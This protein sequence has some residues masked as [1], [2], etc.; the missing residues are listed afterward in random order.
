MQPP[1]LQGPYQLPAFEACS[2]HVSVTKGRQRCAPGHPDSSLRSLADVVHCTAGLD[3]HNHQME[4]QCLQI[5]FFRNFS[6]EESR[7]SHSRM[8]T[9]E[10][11]MYS[12]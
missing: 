2:A 6:L 9:S 7:L 12:A 1:Q 3:W 5:H 8:Q 10:Q 4:M 11:A